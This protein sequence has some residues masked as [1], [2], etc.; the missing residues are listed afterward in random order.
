MVSHNNLEKKRKNWSRFNLILLPLPNNQPLS[1]IIFSQSN[2]FFIFSY[3]PVMK[4]L[5]MSLLLRKQRGSA[6]I[7][8]FVISLMFEVIIV[9]YCLSKDCV[10]WCEC[11]WCISY[12]SLSQ[13]RLKTSLFGHNTLIQ[14]SCNNDCERTKL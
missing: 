1:M 6:I 8:R 10:T 7:R 14:V 5:K 4:N 12:R 9:K 2:N 11:L 13:K 3:G